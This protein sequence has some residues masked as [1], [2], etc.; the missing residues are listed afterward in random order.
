MTKLI[1]KSGGRR[2]EQRSGR[3]DQ[4]HSRELV[5]ACS[6]AAPVPPQLQGPRHA[7]V[8]SVSLLVHPCSHWTLVS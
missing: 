2:D 1:A 8:D 6:S 5:G 3:T 7:A 4:R